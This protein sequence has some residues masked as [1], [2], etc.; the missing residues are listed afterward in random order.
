M[1][2]PSVDLILFFIYL[3]N[4]YDTPYCGSPHR[5]EQKKFKKWLH[6]PRRS[7]T[8]GDD[9]SVKLGNQAMGVLLVLQMRKTFRAECI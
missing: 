3:K 4:T 8:W 9:T 5:L 7:Y 6:L 1:S 2:S